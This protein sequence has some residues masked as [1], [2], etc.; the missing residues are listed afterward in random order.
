M[1]LKRGGQLFYLLSKLHQS[2]CL[3]SLQ[4]R[5]QILCELGIAANGRR[6]FWCAHLGLEA[7]RADQKLAG[8][9]LPRQKGCS[10]PI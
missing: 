3:V 2:Q 10:K 9:D 4:G 7:A 6:P 8:K 5:K 1:D